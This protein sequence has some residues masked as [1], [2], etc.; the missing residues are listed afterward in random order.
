MSKKSFFIAN[1]LVLLGLMNTP[2]QVDALQWDHFTSQNNQL[3]KPF[4]AAPT[5]PNQQTASLVLDV[6][7]DGDQDFVIAQRK[8][9]PSVILYRYNQSNKTW[10]T[11]TIDS[12]LLNIEAGGSVADIDND[13]DLD[14]AFAGDTS[15]NQ[16][17]WWENPQESNPNFTSTWTRRFIKNDGGNKHHDM[18]FGDFDGDGKKELAFWNQKGSPAGKLM[19]AEIPANPKATSLTKWE[20]DTIFT[21][22]DASAEGLIAQDIDGDGKIDLVGAGYWFKHNSGIN[23]TPKPIVANRLFTRSAAGQLVPGGYAEVIIGPGDNSGK[24]AMYRYQNNSWTETVLEAVVENGHSLE[25]ADID[26]NGTLD[27]F[28]AE[29]RLN[30]ANADSKINLYLNNGSGTFN[31]ESV[32]PGGIGNHESKLADLNADGLLDI[33]GKPYNWSTPRVDVWLQ[34][35]NGTNPTPT[36]TN[37]SEKIA[38]NSWQRHVVDANKQWRTVM[39]DSGNIDNDNLPDIVT[40]GW[41]YKNPGT[42]G[43]NWQRNVIG[44]PLRNMAVLYDIDGQ[45]GLDILGTKGGST[46]STNP[47]NSELV[48]AQNNGSGSFTIRQNIPNGTGDFIQ[49]AVAGNLNGKQVALSWHK[50][51][52]GVQLLTIPSN[53][54]TQTWT[55]TFASTT[56]QDE[57]LS[58][59]NIDRTGGLDLLLGTKWLKN[60]ATT[61]S[62]QTLSNDTGHPDRNE[63]ADINNDGKLDAVVGYEAISV[64]GKIAWYQQ[65]SNAT[66]MWTERIIS[67]SVIGPM[68]LD[69]ADMDGDGDIDVVVGEH[70]L[71][72]NANPRLLVFENNNNGSS[73]SQHIVYT[74]DEHH[75][76]AQTVDIDNDGDL[77]IISIGWQNNKVT[78]YENTHRP[79]GQQPTPTNQTNPTPTPTPRPS[80]YDFNS[81]SRINYQDLLLF[82]HNKLAQVTLLDGNGNGKIDIFDYTGIVHRL[83]R[84]SNPPTS[85]TSEPTPTPTSPPTNPNAKELK[86]IDREVQF[87]KSDNGFHVLKANGANIPGIPVNWK[88]PDNYYDGEWH[89][90]YTIVNQ[91]STPTAG[92]LSTCIWNMPGFH[93]ENCAGNISHDGKVGTSKTLSSSPKDWWKNGSDPLDFSN[94]TP[95][96]MRV[97]LRGETSC[98]VTGHCVAKPCEPTGEVCTNGKKKGDYT[99]AFAK[100]DEM[101][102]RLTI[103]M[104]PQG[105]TFSGWQNYP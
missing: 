37:P 66:S 104:V 99:S 67:T 95:F 53:P 102:F 57:D 101:K 29:M 5:P 43:G 71:R 61:W 48:W 9:T 21:A 94:S 20:Y 18:V 56:T 11:H 19:L 22:N 44:D 69:A 10:S 88:S 28:N 24:L 100:Y 72:T 55:R 96:L 52:G 46:S 30:N 36:P 27:I 26:G 73:W 58:L 54:S 91:D 51:G 2:L 50:N 86:L 42:A 23:Y 40:G 38:L 80:N 16:V 79:D 82:I 1:F 41:W 39:I 87:A 64:A 83:T 17:W 32:G 12:N 47:A 81:D 34:K 105:K 14:I 60:N 33:V 103:V 90:R 45:N 62:A 76:G 4:P 74:G 75:D 6:D 89:F 59:G 7:K 25:I 84:Q 92:A 68:S 65:P 15:S 77:D 63:L 70:D 8:A 78:L 35:N 85:P 3:P 31:K 97:V 93:P 13:G 98:N 49:G